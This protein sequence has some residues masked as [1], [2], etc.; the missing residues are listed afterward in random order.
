MYR[1]VKLRN[2]TV[3]FVLED[4]SHVSQPPLKQ[5]NTI[6]SPSGRQIV[7]VQQRFQS[8]QA[9]YEQHHAQI[10][11]LTHNTQSPQILTSDHGSD[12]CSYLPQSLSTQIVPFNSSANLEFTNVQGG[13]SSPNSR[14]ERVEA[15]MQKGN[16]YSNVRSKTR[17]E[18]MVIENEYGLEN[19]KG[20]YWKPIT[21]F[22]MN[23]SSRNDLPSPEEL[24]NFVQDLIPLA[25]TSE[26]FFDKITDLIKKCCHAV[27]SMSTKKMK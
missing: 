12:G 3:G 27:A 25:E 6:T 24:F 20:L 8:P 15:S 5:P 19:A 4:N 11:E 10:I 9:S 2:G 22:C 18:L 14:Q 26:P 13:N 7:Y 21:M 17:R 16:V 1:K 23:Q